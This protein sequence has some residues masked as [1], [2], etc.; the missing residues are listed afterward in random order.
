MLSFKSEVLGFEEC[1][2]IAVMFFRRWLVNQTVW[3][4]IFC[5][6]VSLVAAQ[7]LYV[8]L[9]WLSLLMLTTQFFFY[10]FRANCHCCFW[11]LK[12][13]NLSCLPGVFLGKIYLTLSVTSFPEL[14]IGWLTAVL[15]ICLKI[16]LYIKTNCAWGAL[17]GLWVVLYS[18]QWKGKLH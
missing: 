4:C 3:D 8:H 15:E 12:T 1:A 17:C 13:G 5:W 9:W 6:W 10:L 16:L 14:V 11:K 18:F 7:S 2:S